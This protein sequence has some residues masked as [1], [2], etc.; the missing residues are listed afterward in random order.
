MNLSLEV[1]KIMWPDYE[2]RG[3]DA[4]AVRDGEFFDDEFFNHTTPEALGQ[5]AVWLAAYSFDHLVEIKQEKAG[6]IHDK[7]I[8]ALANADNEALAEAIIATQEGE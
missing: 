3:V 4:Y 8:L 1:A 6:E 2:W 5:M 7:L